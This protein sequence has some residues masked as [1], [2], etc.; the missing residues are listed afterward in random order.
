MPPRDIVL[1]AVRA[2]FTDFDQS[3]A[4]NLLAED[5]RQHNVGVPTGA[6]PILGFIPA[7]K[8]SGIRS[9]IH[10]VVTDQTL[11]KPDAESGINSSS[12]SPRNA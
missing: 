1:S 5:Y 10:R 7:L 9:T 6:A 11:K 4:R 12:R 3:A 8:E 2:I